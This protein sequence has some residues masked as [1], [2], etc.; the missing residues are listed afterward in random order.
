MMVHCCHS[1]LTIVLFMFMRLWVAQLKATKPS[2]SGPVSEWA[3][4]HVAL[5]TTP[6]PTLK[7]PTFYW[8]SENGDRI[9]QHVSFLVCMLFGLWCRQ[10]HP[11]QSNQSL[12]H[13]QA[14]SRSCNV[15]E[16]AWHCHRLAASVR[17]VSSGLC[18][19]SIDHGELFVCI[20]C[21]RYHGHGTGGEL[22]VLGAPQLF[23]KQE[24][25]GWRYQ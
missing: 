24:V 3:S 16:A 7:F 14:P 2:D 5:V 18:R 13:S 6:S 15:P 9:Q 22:F 1:G 11:A 4:L 12:H 25:R 21:W 19:A 20:L 23:L 10:W 8:C 17:S